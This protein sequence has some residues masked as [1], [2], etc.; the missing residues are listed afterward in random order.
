MSAFDEY[1][2]RMAKTSAAD[3]SKQIE[4]LS[5]GGDKYKDARFWKPTVDKQ[6]NGKAVIRFLPAH[7]DDDS[8]FTKIF[9]HGFKIN[10][11]W[12]IENCPKTIGEPCPIC[13]MVSDL[14]D[15]KEDTQIKIAGER[16]RKLSYITN[17]LVLKDENAKENEGKVFLFKFGKKIMDKIIAVTKPEFEDTKPSNPC[18]FY[19]GSNFRLVQKRVESFPNYD[20]S[21]FA[22]PSKLFGGDDS[23]I[24]A[25][26]N[27]LY[28]LKEFTD[29]KL[30]KSAEELEKRWKFVSNRKAAANRKVNLEEE[31]A[32]EAPVKT[33]SSKPAEPSK[34]S[35]SAG[36]SKKATWDEEDSDEDDAMKK[37][38]EIADQD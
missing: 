17:I 15:T 29:P 28:S 35:P 9:N 7:P 14:Y 34:P 3:L 19:E 1:K 23:K 13:D 18:D 31:E 32:D 33:R 30:F 5:G 11:N 4:D 21:T 36:A 37:F 20:S 26:F 27:A 25:V 24:E 38:Q 2:K 12:F 8:P 16:K 10:G 22:E 6:G